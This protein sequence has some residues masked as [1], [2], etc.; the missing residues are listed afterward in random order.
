MGAACLRL[1]ALVAGVA[2]AALARPLPLVIDRDATPPVVLAGVD[3]GGTSDAF[4][5]L[6]NRGFVTRFRSDCFGPS[7]SVRQTGLCRQRSKELACLY[8]GGNVES[9]RACYGRFRPREE[10]G[11]APWMDATPNYL[12]GWINAEDVASRL[13]SVSPRSTVVLL[14]REPVARLR[15]LFSYWQSQPIRDEVGDTLEEHVRADLAFLEAMSAGD[16][17]REEWKG[18]TLVAERNI[19]VPRLW[20]D[21]GHEVFSLLVREYPLWLGRSVS[22]AACAR[23]VG[24]KQRTARGAYESWRTYEPPAAPAP[25]SPCPPEKRKKCPRSRGHVPPPCPARR[26]DA[27]DRA[28]PRLPLSPCLLGPVF[29]NFVLTSLYAPLVR[30]WIDTFPGRVAV[31]QSEHYFSRR[32]ALFS[33]LGLDADDAALEEAAPP[34]SAGVV[35]NRGRYADDNA[36]LSPATLASLRA[37]YRGRPPVSS[38]ETTGPD[39]AEQPSSPAQVPTTGSGRSCGRGAGPPPSRPTPPPRAPGGRVSPSRAL[40]TTPGAGR[41]GEVGAA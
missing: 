24:S 41:Q 3:K 32:S 30:H 36:T 26:P 40:P 4:Q 8:R 39:G 7:M 9:W 12:W 13:A 35:V 6:L 18:R 38:P 34:A 10:D 14:L 37:F 16:Y 29:V 20:G 17:L 21:D 19:S 27:G 28:A 33:V 11:G 22:K 15:S 31:V 5:A 25:R 23:M 2:A 1:F